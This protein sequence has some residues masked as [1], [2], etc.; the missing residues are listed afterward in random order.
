M[1]HPGHARLVTPP[2]SAGAS[3]L[4]RAMADPLG[5]EHSYPTPP[6]KLR[7]LVEFT[8]KQAV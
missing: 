1:M 8:V 5:I 2:F 4:Y 3:D 7:E 6:L